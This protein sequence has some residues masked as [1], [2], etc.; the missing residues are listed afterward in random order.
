MYICCL[1]QIC[2][3][4]MCMCWR[5]SLYFL[6]LRS[7]SSLWPRLLRTH[8]LAAAWN[9]PCQYFIQKLCHCNCGAN[10][11]T[12]R[13]HCADSCKLSNC[14]SFRVAQT[15]FQIWLRRVRL[16]TTLKCVYWMAM[17]RLGLHPSCGC[18]KTHQSSNCLDLEQNIS[19]QKCKITMC[20]KAETTCLATKQS[21]QF[22]E[23]VLIQMWKVDTGRGVLCEEQLQ[24]VRH[25]I[26]SSTPCS[27]F[28]AVV[29]QM[30]KVKSN[31][32]SVHTC[33]HT[34]H[35]CVRSSLPL[36]NE[37]WTTISAAVWKSWLIDCE[38]WWT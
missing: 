6:V 18:D 28:S 4:S 2:L 13:F 14:P 11:H 24:P 26:K 36:L 32:Y 38:S 3:S 9:I 21:A 16:G 22:S 20:N 34:S 1:V 23:L 27:L 19:C 30:W 5:L 31:V 33:I 25:F 12:S 8:H 10:M 37:T 29:L 17:Y 15:G 7:I 35:C